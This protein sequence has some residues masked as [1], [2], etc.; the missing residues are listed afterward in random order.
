MLGLAIHPVAQ[1]ALWFA[2]IAG[3]LAGLAILMRNWRG[4]AAE[5]QQDPSDMLT[6][7]RDLY[8]AGGLS[9]EEYRTIKL[10]LATELQTEVSNRVLNPTAVNPTATSGNSQREQSADKRMTTDELVTDQ[11][12]N[13]ITRNETES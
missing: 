8:S 1:V 13:E 10:K 7:F 2:L 5:D 6:K 9:E 12:L 11:L 3:M 4:S